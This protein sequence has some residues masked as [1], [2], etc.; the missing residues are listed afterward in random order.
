MLSP[1]TRGTDR[2]EKLR[3]YQ[4]LPC[5]QAYAMVEPDI[6]QIEVARW[7]DGEVTWTSFGPGDIIDTPFC[8]WALNGIYDAI[9]AM[10]TF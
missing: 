8:P 3:G 2:R 6:R 4:T 10:A 1:S 5:I 7:H 9:D